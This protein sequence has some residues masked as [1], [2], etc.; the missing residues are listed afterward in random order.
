MCASQAPLGPFWPFSGPLVLITAPALFL[1]AY[2]NPFVP[3]T[4]ETEFAHPLRVHHPSWPWTSGWGAGRGKLSSLLWVRTALDFP[5]D[6]SE[7]TPN[8]SLPCQRPP[9]PDSFPWGPCLR[10]TSSWILSQKHWGRLGLELLRDLVFLPE[11][12]L[13]EN[14]GKLTA[15]FE[16]ATADKLKCQEEAEV[17]AGT[18][19]LANRLV[20]VSSS[21]WALI[22]LAELVKY[23]RGA[24]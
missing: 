17:T 10:I 18:I 13:N 21:G 8:F 5:W 19:S 16:K 14:L 11:Q 6:S 3:S 20:S 7:I 4:G 22:I 24:K 1:A 12:R 2:W 23:R 9:V 15:K